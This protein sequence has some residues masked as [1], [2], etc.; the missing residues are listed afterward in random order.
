MTTTAL[1][2][3]VVLPRGADCA[4][5]VEEFGDGLRHLRGVR[6]VT[7]DVPRG[8]LHVSFDNDLLAYDDLTR[9]ARRIGA[10]AHCAV[11]CPRDGTRSAPASSCSTR[12]A[13]I[14]TSSAW[15]TSPASTAPTAPSSSRAPCSTPTAS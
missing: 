12:A 15:R 6:N 11:H 1:D 14:A 9:D 8:L 3:P 10:A 7:A 13:P 2:L 5:C 4:A